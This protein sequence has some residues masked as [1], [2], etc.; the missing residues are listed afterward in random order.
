MKHILLVV[1]AVIA[2]MFD[3]AAS[4]DA[5]LCRFVQ[6]SDSRAR[7]ELVVKSSYSGQ[8]WGGECSSDEV[9]CV[10]G[11]NSV[12]TLRYQNIDRYIQPNDWRISNADSWCKA[13]RGWAYWFKA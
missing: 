2:C 7:Y 9:F 4:N 3:T 12:V 8:A 10:Y 6:G 5:T 1:L 11:A 13:R